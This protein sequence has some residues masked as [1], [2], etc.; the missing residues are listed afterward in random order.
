M[1]TDVF[2]VLALLF[3]PGIA[4]AA[5]VRMNPMPLRQ[6]FRT[7]ITS[8]LSASTTEEGES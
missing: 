7:A 5:E 8:N 2:V 4:L 3:G 1:L 6:R